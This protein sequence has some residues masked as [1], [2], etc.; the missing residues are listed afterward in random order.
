MIKLTMLPLPK[1]TSAKVKASPKGNAKTDSLH[2]YRASRRFFRVGF[3]VE[4][5]SKDNAHYLILL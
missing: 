4:N 5:V 1:Y 3:S 2:F